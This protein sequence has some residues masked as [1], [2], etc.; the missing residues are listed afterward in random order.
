MVVRCSAPVRID[1]AGAWTDV[2]IFADQFGGA[3]LNAAINLRIHGQMSDGVVTE[4][5]GPS[6]AQKVR[7]DGIQVSYEMRL[8]AGSGLGTSA[9]M[10]VLWLALVRRQRVETLQDRE[11]LAAIS[12][13]LERVL[14]ILG[15]KQDQY[16]SAVGGI[17]LFEF[18]EGAVVTNPVML[19]DEQIAEL[20]ARLVLCYTGK[21]RLSSR[22]HEHVWGNFRAGN[23]DTLDALFTLRDSAYEARTALQAGEFKRFGQLLTTQFACAKRLHES[24]SNAQIEELFAAVSPHAVGFKPCGAGGG[25]C[26]L[27]CCNDAGER[28][29]VER[30]ITDR[31]LVLQPFRFDFKGLEVEI[32]DE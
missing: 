15:G 26:V 16:A 5:Q 14:G 21:P 6:G 30:L 24:T 22:I 23:R 3:T 8:P 18:R 11:R 9:A 13:D 32:E 27:V 29:A 4:V 12:F 10:N 17:N 1:F 28:L 25:G 7:Q 19:S 31:G 20:E 2:P